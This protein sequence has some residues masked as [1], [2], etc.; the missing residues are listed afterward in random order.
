MATAWPKYLPPSAQTRSDGIRSVLLDAIFRYSHGMATLLLAVPVTLG[1][2]SQAG[3]LIVLSEAP[4]L[5][6]ALSPRWWYF[7]PSCA[8]SFFKTK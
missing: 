4:V 8:G 2:T 7:A 1:A 6:Q 5:M 3:E